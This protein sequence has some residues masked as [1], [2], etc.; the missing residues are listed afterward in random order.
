MLRSTKVMQRIVLS[1]G[2]KARGL[3][4]SSKTTTNQTRDTCRR[5]REL[6]TECP[7]LR[8]RSSRSKQ[9]SLFQDPSGL[10]ESTEVLGTSRSP[11]TPQAMLC[12]PTRLENHNR[13]YFATTQPPPQAPSRPS[14]P[15]CSGLAAAPS[16]IKMPT[17]RNIPPRLARH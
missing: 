17:F 2:A 9:T 15:N 13:F 4:A 3:D 12:D 14:P 16:L 11:T 10:L 6:E 7:H 8:P 1:C 5:Q